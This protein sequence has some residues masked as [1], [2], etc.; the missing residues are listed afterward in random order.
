MLRM[1]RENS[2]SS[3]KIIKGVLIVTLSTLFVMYALF[4]FAWML[5]TSFKTNPEAMSIPITWIPERPTFQS[6][7]QIWKGYHFIIY[8]MNSMLVASS[9]ALLA[10]FIG[11]LAGYGF[12]RS[13]FRGRT[14]LI[15]AFL[16]TQMISGT[17]IIGP[18]FKILAKLGLYNTRFGL[19]IA[20]TTICLPFCAWMTKGY[21]DTIPPEIDQAAMVD[22]CSRFQAFLLVV[23]PLAVPGMVATILF[24]FLLAW[25]DL[26]WAMTLTATESTRTV[27]VGLAFFVGQFQVNW[28]M[29]MAATLVASL[30]SV[31][32]YVF[33]QRALVRG[34][35]A[36][37]VKQ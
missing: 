29:L 21:F 27:T 18:Y 23:S 20:L 10:T 34:L 31:L 4:P 26:L 2:K 32:L 15:G 24:S 16:A 11:A 13:K 19:M 33:L 3:H 6:Y 25:Q 12:S 5:A 17:V 36:G 7:T 28:P 14:F 35:T 8:F 37:A 22:G 1:Q 9:T 30:P